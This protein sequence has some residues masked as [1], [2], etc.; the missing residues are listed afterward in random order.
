MKNNRYHVNFLPAS[1]FTLIEVLL[2]LAVIAIALT[3]LLKVTAQDVVN[4]HRLKEKTI[5]HWVASQGIT[6]I[7]LGLLTPP[8]A[9]Q[10]LTK[11]TTMFGQRW[12]W[13][14]QIKPTSLKSVYQ[15]TITTSQIQ[16][17]PFTDPLIAFWYKP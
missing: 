5:S 1:G 16:G 10:P 9:N 12:Y 6:M 11:V 17:G 13:R 2:A 15:I 7:Q 14:P 4:T 8:S 3:T